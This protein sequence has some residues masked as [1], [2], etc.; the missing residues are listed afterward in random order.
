MYL[1]AEWITISAP[2][3]KG[4]CN[5]GV[6]KQLSTISKQLWAWAME[7]S[8]EMSAISIKGLEGVSKNKKRVLGF[9]AASQAAVSIKSTKSVSTRILL[10]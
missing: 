10:I 9:I 2:N 4:F 8:A 1:V 3:S 7:A 5:T 6:Q